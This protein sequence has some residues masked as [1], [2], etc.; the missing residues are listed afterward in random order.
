MIGMML[1]KNVQSYLVV[2][3]LVFFASNLSAQPSSNSNENL[4]NVYFF[5]G[6]REKL[7]EN[8]GAAA[9]QFERFLALN[10][11]SD[12][13]LYEL[14][15]AQF[16]LNN[17]I[18][19]ELNI[20]KAIA[21]NKKN[22][23]YFR[24]KAEILK[25][26]NNISQLVQVYEDLI[27]LEP[28]NESF[29]LEKANA[30]YLSSRIEDVKK[31]YDEMESKFGIS[32]KLLEARKALNLF[33]ND[34]PL[35][36]Q[37]IKLLIDKD[38]RQTQ[39]YLYMVNLQLAEGNYEEALNTLKFAEGITGEHF[40]YSLAKAIIYKS[41]EQPDLAFKAVIE[42]FDDQK[43]D[44]DR[45]YLFLQHVL[46]AS[47]QIS[48]KDY[49]VKIVE[50]LTD[51]YP[52]NSKAF[53][54]YGEI[55]YKIGSLKKSADKFEIAL[56]LNDQNFAIWE[57]LIYIQTV[58]GNYKEVIRVVDEALSSYPNQAI[59]YYFNAFSRHR[60]GEEVAHNHLDFAL[61]LDTDN[62]RLSSCIYGLK[63]EIALNSGKI[64]MAEEYFAKATEIDPLN[65]VL[66]NSYA[67]FLASKKLELKL[68]VELINKAIK[69]EPKENTHAATY[70]FI[71]KQMGNYSEAKIWID[72]ALSNNAHENPVYLELNGDILF[73][74]GLKEE[75][76][77]QWSKALAEGS[78]SEKL[79][80]KIN[81]KT[82]IN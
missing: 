57:K 60:N 26:T 39:N 78:K 73:L 18:D 69:N 65:N 33:N 29:Y 63:A 9:L 15:V 74:S 31:V 24:H 40:E 47:D 7:K 36:I 68:A 1:K 37:S 10:P 17:F 27:E 53:T 71:L 11:A 64:K 2:G 81:G 23:W 12:A 77:L 16:R 66:F 48:N 46:G 22:V 30:F 72:K 32:N 34:R 61:Q 43:M 79:I 13:G 75:A 19:S 67:Y 14:S 76:L 42:A 25:K 35:D 8:Y 6:L 20:R 50:K 56:K 4:S 21:I 3:L 70:A 5:E 58:L 82:Y 41:L 45:K 28:L 44:F 59:L 49:L 51:Q 38:P 55:L 80:R 54:I 52:D 62:K